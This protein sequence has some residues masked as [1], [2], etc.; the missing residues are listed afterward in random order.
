M[1][2]KTRSKARARG[3]ATMAF[4]DHWST[5][6]LTTEDRLQRIQ[7]LQKLINGHIDFMC[8]D[9]RLND[10]SSESR[11]NAVNDFY[12]CLVQRERELA[13]I[14]ESLQLS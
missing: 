10:S 1:L 13:R 14:R 3:I 9:D 2:E 4:D 5:V 12:Q 7:A 8:S 6:A 11:E